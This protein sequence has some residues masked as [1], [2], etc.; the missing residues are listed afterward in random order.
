MN[1]PTRLACGAAHDSRLT[2][3]TGDV[4]VTGTRAIAQ[5]YMSVS[6]ESRVG[7]VH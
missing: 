2:A 5:V 4:A 3:S 7:V 6:S 1:L